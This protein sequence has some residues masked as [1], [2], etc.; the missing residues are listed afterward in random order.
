[1]TGNIQTHRRVRPGLRRG[2]VVIFALLLPLAAHSLWDYVEARRLSRA[3]EDIR[4]RGE[5]LHFGKEREGRP[6]TPE[7]MRASR[8]YA[9]AAHLVRD[10][11]GKAFGAA[12]QDIDAVA[13]LGPAKAKGDRRLETLRQLAEQYDPA[14]DLLDR[15]AHLDARGLDHGDELRYGLPNKSLADLNALRVARLAF[16]GESRMAAEALVSTL[17]IRRAYA[18]IFWLGWSAD[19]NGSLRLIL[20]FAPPTDAELRMLQS[21]YARWDVDTDVEA[22]LID[23]RARYLEPI[24]PAVTGE[25]LNTPRL[26]DPTD[27]GRTPRLVDLAVRPWVTRRVTQML[28]QYEEALV[29][30]RQPWPVK[31]DAARNLSARYPGQNVEPSQSS[32]FGG[33]RVVRSLFQNNVAAREL[34]TLVRTVGTETARRRVAIT[35]LAVERYRRA[36]GG[37]APQTLADLVPT[38]LPS[39]PIDPF[40]GAPIRYVRGTD[41]YK[42]YSIGSNRTDDGGDWSAD[43]PLKVGSWSTMLL[44]KDL[45]FDVPIGPQ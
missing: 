41:R 14:L 23:T 37:S 27:R 38:Y 35:A 4:Q 30:A 36:H 44:K 32:G 7:Q 42:I 9:A 2:A 34:A 33:F 28:R 17:R 25:M 15:A 12:T 29:A 8:Y 13:A 18:D 21:E 5:R 11:Y 45:G 6:I 40:S 1:M 20:E 22:R 19:T 3:V 26:T 43:E 24:W 39:Q 16:L 31:L 10:T